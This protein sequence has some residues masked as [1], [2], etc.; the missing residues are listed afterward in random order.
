V[1]VGDLSEDEH[2]DLILRVRQ[3]KGRKDRLVPLSR[4]AEAIVRAYLTARKLKRT[5]KRDAQEYLFPSRKGRGH[6]GLSTRRLRGIVEQYVKAAGVNKP[7]SPHSLR[8]TAAITWLRDSA[9]PVPVVQKL[10]GH[11]SLSTTQR[12]VDHLEIE[13][14]KEV[15]NRV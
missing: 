3:G 14:L 10:L 12:Y 6:G 15:V 11:A 2:E 7:I 8:H 4:D 9:A 1:R 13:E 5:S